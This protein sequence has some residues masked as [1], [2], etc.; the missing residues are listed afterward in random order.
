MSNG[1]RLEVVNNN[2]IILENDKETFVFTSFNG[3]G[4]NLPFFTNHTL[5]NAK[6][7]MNGISILCLKYTEKHF[8]DYYLIVN[9]DIVSILS[10]HLCSIY[11]MPGIYG[12]TI[13]K[14]NGTSQKYLRS[15]IRKAEN[16]MNNEVGGARIFNIYCDKESIN[17]SDIR[18][19]YVYTSINKKELIDKC[20][21]I[22]KLCLG[23]TPYYDY[24]EKELFDQI[25]KKPEED[26]DLV[27][28]SREIVT[29]YLKTLGMSISDLI[30][31]TTIDEIGNYEIKIH[32]V[33]DLESKILVIS[34]ASLMNRNIYIVIQPKSSGNL[35]LK[36]KKCNSLDEH[37]QIVSKILNN[38]KNYEYLCCFTDMLDQRDIRIIKPI[39]DTLIPRF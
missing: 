13:H 32:D 3:S 15:K 18:E 27:D 29:S 31:P 35:L 20:V 6:K 24:E 17:I 8:I 34:Y 19:G 12:Y 28:R 4:T 25:W 39:V 14:S 1:V 23:R 21:Q 2:W 16:M 10:K 36:K 11:T 22:V 9:T 33:A 37:T 38:I 7:L 30:K 26:N 5:F